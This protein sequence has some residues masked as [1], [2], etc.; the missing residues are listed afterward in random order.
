MAAVSAG[1]GIV[2]TVLATIIIR[3]QIQT[4]LR[5]RLIKRYYKKHIDMLV[6]E[7]DEPA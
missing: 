5:D 3:P 2:F 4:S 1:L 6:E 7:P